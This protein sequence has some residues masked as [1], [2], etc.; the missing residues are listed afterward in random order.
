MTGQLPNEL[1]FLLPSWDKAL[2]QHVC[3]SRL[4]MYV[5][6]QSGDVHKQCDGPLSIPVQW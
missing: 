3:D 5:N 6:H 1:F 2:P 4:L